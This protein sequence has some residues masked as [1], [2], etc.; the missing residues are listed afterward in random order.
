MTD[1]SPGD[2]AIEQDDTS[3]HRWP[4]VDGTPLT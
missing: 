4:D 3:R 1:V 2:G